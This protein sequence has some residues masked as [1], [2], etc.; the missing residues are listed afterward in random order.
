MKYEYYE[1]QHVGIHTKL[2]SNELNE[3]IHKT[4]NTSY[5]EST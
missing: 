1:L 4:T 5:Y 3:I 2:G